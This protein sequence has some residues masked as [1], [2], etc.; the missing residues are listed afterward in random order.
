MTA[1]TIT[2]TIAILAAGL[3]VQA[4][5]FFLLGENFPA[6]LPAFASMAAVISQAG[7]SK[8]DYME[9][10][11]AGLAA[12]VMLIPFSGTAAVAAAGIIA[13]PAGTIAA[14]AVFSEM[15][16]NNEEAFSPVFSIF[17]GTMIAGMFIMASG[18]AGIPLSG[19]GLILREFTA[20][21]LLS[22]LAGLSGH[23][24]MILLK[25]RVD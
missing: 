20:L 12:G 10:G 6:V 23:G 4:A 24:I 5:S 18:L 21:L 15:N 3:A 11:I 8:A 25:K 17:S 9:A 1:G 14:L 7:K 2:T 13:C 16:R 22:L 19:P